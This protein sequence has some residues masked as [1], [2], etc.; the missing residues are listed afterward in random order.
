M[1]KDWDYLIILDACRYDLFREV[2]KDI[3]WVGKEINH[4]ISKGSHSEEF[5][6]KNFANETFHDTIYVT[7]NAYG[8][9]IADEVFHDL[10]FSGGL[11]DKENA[12][13]HSFSENMSP[14]AMHDLALDTIEE[15]PNKRVIIH[16]MQPHSPYF[17]SKA[18]KL[19][20][21]V[22]NEGLIVRSRQRGKVQE[23]PLSEE[24]VVASL[25]GAAKKGYIS[26]SELTQVYIENLQLVLYHVG[27]LVNSVNGKVVITADHGEYLGENGNIGHPRHEYSEI[28][29][30]VP[31][32]IINSKTR[33]NIIEEEPQPQSEINDRDIEKQLKHLGYKA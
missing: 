18:E 13:L 33:P 11:V 24:N 16:F 10:V 30:K 29:R 21:R 7:A 22:E 26:D 6:E 31:W 27:E 14:E 28:L 17:G 2:S 19:R 20:K 23:F 25:M 1:E 8:A 15:Y 9:Q 5:C 3:P 4:I 12:N 32:V